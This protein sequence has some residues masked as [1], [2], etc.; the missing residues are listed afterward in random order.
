MTAKVAAR[1]PCSAFKYSRIYASLRVTAVIFRKI[2]AVVA[3]KELKAIT[4]SRDVHVY[5]NGIGNFYIRH[6]YFPNYHARHDKFLNFCSIPVNY[7]VFY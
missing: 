5:T 1:I 2:L 4:I 7:V 3:V 6:V